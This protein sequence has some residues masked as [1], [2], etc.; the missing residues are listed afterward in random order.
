M[1]RLKLF[2]VGQITDDPEGWSGDRIFVVAGSAEEAAAMTD[3][4]SAIEVR[5]DRPFVL[6]HFYSSE[7]L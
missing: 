5:M 4:D 3:L 7:N 2:V 1:G 6:C